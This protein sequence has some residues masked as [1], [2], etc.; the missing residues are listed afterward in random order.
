MARIILYILLQADFSK[1]K[2]VEC[3]YVTNHVALKL[4][5]LFEYT[6]VCFKTR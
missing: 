4:T 6:N 2:L 1:L 5:T 3:S